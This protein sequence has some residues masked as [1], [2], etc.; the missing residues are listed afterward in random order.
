MA[1]LLDTNICIYFARG[2]S[3]ALLRRMNEQPTG[4]LH[5]SAVTYAELAVG[6]RTSG[7]DS[8][9]DDRRLAAL[10]RLINV[11]PFDASAAETYGRIGRS[12]PIKRASFDR[13][14]AAHALSLGLTL[15]TNN[16]PYFA[17]VPGLKVEN[18]TRA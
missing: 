14:I 5:M 3:S 4:S 9:A 2:R 8:A 7:P 10:T 16:E 15:V 13:L 18:W 1:Y 6:A 11:R 12:V 17:D